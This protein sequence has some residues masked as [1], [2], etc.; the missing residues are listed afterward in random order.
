MSPIGTPS[1]IERR[2]E[3]DV[4]VFKILVSELDRKEH[5]RQEYIDALEGAVANGCRHLVLDLSNLKDTNH[6]WGLFQ[7]IFI[8]NQTLHD[9]GG[10]LVISG[11]KR[12]IR[13]V[14]RIADLDELFPTYKSDKKAVDALAGSQSKAERDG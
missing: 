11:M 3:G 4:V 2:V 10:K 7:L 8:A 1:W 5:P 14:F 12:Y 6:T 9:E 13:K